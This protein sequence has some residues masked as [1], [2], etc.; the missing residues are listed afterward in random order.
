MYS[1]PA[2]DKS[3]LE[4]ILCCKINALA[5]D[6]TPVWTLHPSHV[7]SPLR[8]VPVPAKTAIIVNFHAILN[9]R[10]A[11]QPNS[12]RALVN[13]AS[14][15]ISRV[16]HLE[17]MRAPHDAARY[18]G[19]PSAVAWAQNVTN[20]IMPAGAVIAVVQ[21]QGDSSGLGFT[22]STLLQRAEVDIDSD[23]FLP[24]YEDVRYFVGKRL[25]RIISLRLLDD[26]QE[27][28]HQFLDHLSKLAESSRR[29]SAKIE[30]QVQ[31][32]RRRGARINWIDLERDTPL[33]KA[34]RRGDDKVAQLLLDFGADCSVVD[35]H[36]ASA[37]HYLAQTA[38]QMSSGSR[39]LALLHTLA[40][41]CH[42]TIF[43][44][45]ARGRTPLMIASSEG[46]VFDRRRPGKAHVALRIV[47]AL[48]GYGGVAIVGMKD[49]EMK[50]ALH[51]AI[52]S[53][54]VNPLL[55]HE[56]LR[57]GAD[58][59]VRDGNGY[60]A[61]DML[62]K[63]IDA[64]IAGA[65]K[66][67]LLGETEKFVR[68]HAY[69]GSGVAE[70][71]AEALGKSVLDMSS[72]GDTAAR[73][74]DPLIRRIYDTLTSRDGNETCI[75][76]VESEL[77]KGS[78]A[79][80][81]C[82]PSCGVFQ[83]IFQTLVNHGAVVCAS[84]APRNFLVQLQEL[85]P[86]LPPC[87]QISAQKGRFTSSVLQAYCKEC[88]DYSIRGMVKP[89][90]KDTGDCSGIP[91]IDAADM[92]P[93]IFWAEHFMKLRPVLVTN[94]LSDNSWENAR[95]I[96]GNFTE[97]QHLFHKSSVKVRVASIPYAAGFGIEQHE[98]S[99]MN[100]TQQIFHGEGPAKDLYLFAAVGDRRNKKCGLH[101]TMLPTAG[102]FDAILG[103][104]ARFER[105]FEQIYLGRK[106]TGSPMHFHTDAVNALV[107]GRKRW[108]VASPK[109]SFY[110]L[111][112]ASSFF[113]RTLPTILG[114]FEEMGLDVSICDQ[115]AGSI[116]YIP[117]GF[118]HAVLNLETSVGTAIE[119]SVPA[120]L[121]RKPE[122][123]DVQIPIKED[124]VTGIILE[125][126][127]LQRKSYEGTFQDV[128]EALVA[129]RDPQEDC[130]Y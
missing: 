118:S 25:N 1:V 98:I 20:A 95:R 4:E 16:F 68:S 42:G 43:A 5:D 97:L 69:D 10:G 72:L 36:G 94:A 83:S 9:L 109:S 120:S 57:S 129:G 76:D 47:K 18:R 80:H 29:E 64:A 56:L 65:T 126:G 106:D 122:S 87:P 70:R 71:C 117:R 124:H 53:S 113:H 108:V 39:S 45:D 61:L 86:A 67:I 107:A 52:D 31:G 103:L 85:H 112:N 88:T 77:Q 32:L 78:T 33:I 44:K 6:E 96:W 14:H 93:E 28:S 22:S 63:R 82:R 73:R 128:R 89:V 116:F 21:R 40:R 41:E 2:F 102:D 60:G 81:L 130:I 101:D 58:P 90:T 105:E 75:A 51:H 12:A 91:V 38:P 62:W 104:D 123:P 79:F 46:Y 34:I 3:R 17:A 11:S 23:L 30:M 74:A 121:G 59:N 54:N 7:C 92:S 111:E 100:Y 99:M 15:F 37:L 26:V 13:D 24:S 84:S 114:R 49:N 55:L 110:S 27:L 48:I 125:N 19:D 66:A 50:T 8:E 115:P 127:H 35:V 119:F